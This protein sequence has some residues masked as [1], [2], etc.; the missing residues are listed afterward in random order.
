MSG[1]DLTVRI[2]D[3]VFSNP[4]WAA[5]GTFGYA[6]EFADFVDLKNVGAIITKTVTLNAREGNA[7]P[8]IV[9]TASGLL[10]SI[11]L[12]N[13]GIDNFKKEKYPFLRKIGTKII[14]SVAGFCAEEFIRCV[15]KLEEE[16]PD[17]IELNLSC[18]NVRHKET[19]YKLIS[20]DPESAK[21]IVSS[22]R[23][24]TKAALIAK[25]SPNVTDISLI[26]KAV[27]DAGIDAVSLVNTYSAMAVE[28]ETMK[29]VLGNITG[30]LSGP[31]IKPMALKA[32][33]DV[34]NRV[35]VPVIGIGGI[36]TGLDAVEFML[37]GAAAVQ[38][39]TANFADP[40]AYG[41]ILKEFKDYLKKKKIKKAASITGRLQT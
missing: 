20:Q 7:P 17:A 2:G 31:A 30:G 3:I 26:A 33:W 16:T 19:R 5:S 14:V 13:K 15:E 25:L 29:P 12:E 28:A 11:G 41:R 1:M 36:M 37:C 8:R 23:K 22:V 10:N 35:D 38:I 21:K 18:P 39:G 24:R 40:D 6:E 34:Y 32:V 9:E 27:E 4:L